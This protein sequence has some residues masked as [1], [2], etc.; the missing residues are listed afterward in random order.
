[1]PDDARGAALLAVVAAILVGAAAGL[2][3][4]TV[5]YA[6]GLAYLEDD[7]VACA[8][9]HVMQE[10][11]DAWAK[12]SHKEAAVCNDCHAPHTNLVDKYTC[13]ARNGFFHSYAFTTGEF[14]DNILITPTNRDVTEAAC[15]HC[16]AA[17]SHGIDDAAEPLAC[18]GCHASVGHDTH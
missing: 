6:D 18:T 11:L 8:N 16:H 5:A 13:K 9:C 4:Y 1:M 15:R 12:S 2:G 14:P 17:V 7:P 10:H 3:S